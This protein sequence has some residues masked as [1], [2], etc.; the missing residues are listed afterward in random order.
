RMIPQARRPAQGS[1]GSCGRRS[2]VKES[3]ALAEEGRSQALKL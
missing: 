3:L 2:E 1:E